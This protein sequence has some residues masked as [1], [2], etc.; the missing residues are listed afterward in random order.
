M[1]SS[2]RLVFF[3]GT[4][5]YNHYNDKLGKQNVPCCCKL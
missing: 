4:F 1:L 2:A 5:N 3:I